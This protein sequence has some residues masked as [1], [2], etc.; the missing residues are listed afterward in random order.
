MP[1]RPLKYCIVH[2]FYV[3]SLSV[4]KFVTIRNIWPHPNSQ[5]YKNHRCHS[6]FLLS[7]EGYEGSHSYY[8][9][10]HNVTLQ[11]FHPHP[12]RTSSQ[13]QVTSRRKMR[14]A[15][16]LVVH[17]FHFYYDV[18]ISFLSTF[19]WYLMCF[20]LGL[21]FISCLRFWPSNLGGN[22]DNAFKFTTTVNRRYGRDV[23]CVTDAS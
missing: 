15:F 6:L 9:R 23:R 18:L 3:F 17:H 7:F 19:L 16:A 13:R 2:G 11:L 10:K 1:K 8:P 20:A 14:N 12:R 5:D 22:N 21:L 4:L